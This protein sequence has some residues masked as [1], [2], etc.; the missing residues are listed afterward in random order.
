MNYFMIVAGTSMTGKHYTTAG[1]QP[2]GLEHQYFI[3]IVVGDPGQNPGK[4]WQTKYN[5]Y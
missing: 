5:P 4:G 3:L 1:P 2:S